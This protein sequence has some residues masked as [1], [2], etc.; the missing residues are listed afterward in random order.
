M[1]CDWAKLSV[2]KVPEV[3][4][5]G[6]GSALPWG[7]KSQRQE[8]DTWVLRTSYSIC[9]EACSGIF[10]CFWACDMLPRMHLLGSWNQR[11][12]CYGEKACLQFKYAIDSSAASPVCTWLPNL[13]RYISYIRSTC[14]MYNTVQSQ[15]YMLR[16]TQ[17][18]RALLEAYSVPQ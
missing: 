4:G 15:Y 6:I 10:Q 12:G 17:A 13:G 5:D 11:T 14:Y 9:T 16:H 7:N 3:L 1:G 18:R 2:A 8:I